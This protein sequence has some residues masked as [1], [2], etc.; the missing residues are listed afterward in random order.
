L[1]VPRPLPE[2]SS[3]VGTGSGG[4]GGSGGG[5]GE[6]S[7]SGGTQTPLSRDRPRFSVPVSPREGRIASTVSSGS[8]RPALPARPALPFRGRGRLRGDS[9]RGHLALA[10]R[11]IARPASVPAVLF[12]LRYR[13]RR[14]SSARDVRQGKLQR[15][16][17]GR[18]RPRVSATARV[19]MMMMAV[20]TGG[21]SGAADT[22]IS[23]RE[24]SHPVPA[25]AVVVVVAAVPSSVVATVGVFFFVPPSLTAAIAV[26]AVSAPRLAFLRRTS[27]VWPAGRWPRQGVQV[28]RVR[29]AVAA[30]AIPLPIRVSAGA[31]G[32]GRADGARGLPSLRRRRPAC[33]LLRAAVTTTIAAAIVAGAPIFMAGLTHQ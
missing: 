15:R 13:G 28:V 12:L 23:R 33:P 14:A 16:R 31:G 27:A 25:E 8:D 32:S 19:A 5:F 1:L 3:P 2:V 18:T 11:S 21:G 4:G 9:R 30:A 17:G 26:S 10:V 6:R 29:L 22:V 20:R 7:G 24:R